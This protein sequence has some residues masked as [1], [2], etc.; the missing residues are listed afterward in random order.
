VAFMTTLSIRGL[1]A[2]LVGGLSNI[3]STFAAGLLLGV[4]E[5]VIS[6][7]SPISGITDVVVAG[8]V[9]VLMVVRPSGLGRSSY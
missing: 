8:V 6:F 7:K 3:G 1:A 9:L 4:L 2:A 5:A